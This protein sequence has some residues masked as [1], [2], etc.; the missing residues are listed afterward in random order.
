MN[1][2]KRIPLMVMMT[3]LPAVILISSTVFGGTYAW[4]VK[5]IENAEVGI[6]GQMGEV[7]I[8]LNNGDPDNLNLIDNDSDVPIILRVR[9]AAEWVDK[10]GGLPGVPPGDSGNGN[11]EIIKSAFT[12]L[13][14]AEWQ[15]AAGENGVFLIYVNGSEKIANTYAKIPAHQSKK[16]PDYKIPDQDGWT[17]EFTFIA[18]ALQATDN[19]YD[20]T[21]I[22]NTDG[23]TS[24]AVTIP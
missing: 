2:T 14:T 21:T 5:Q 17:L 24:W 16:I 23:V 18:E 9:V 15:L 3:L 4:F 13:D 1:K 11:I 6:T 7:K 12:G 20:Y 19:A 22:N 8:A 10:T